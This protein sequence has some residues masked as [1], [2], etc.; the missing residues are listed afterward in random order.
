MTLTKIRPNNDIKPVDVE[1]GIFIIDIINVDEVTESFTADFLINL[2]WHDPR[3]SEKALGFSLEDYKLSL[4]DIWHP[5]IHPINLRELTEEKD[6][7]VEIDSDGK[8]RFSERIYGE[9]SSPLNLNEFP[10]DIQSLNIQ[11]ASF[12][13]GPQD[14]IFII[15]SAK[16]GIVDVSFLGGWDIIENISNVDVDP[17]RGVAGAHTRLV[18]SI[19]IERHVG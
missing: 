12:E 11:I 2:K 18:H 19:V 6:R 14:V 9:L 15:D 7:D 16:T 5:N 1:I 4:D 8:I 10:F 17:M 3:L 13:Y